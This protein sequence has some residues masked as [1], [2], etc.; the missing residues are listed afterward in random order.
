MVGAG[1]FMP[2]RT[3][4]EADNWMESYLRD[5]LPAGV[6]AAYAD[7]VLGCLLGGA[8]G[9]AF[10][11]EVEF[12]S[13]AVVRARYGDQ[14]IQ[15]PV[16]H[17]GRLVVSDDT[18]MTLFTL[19]GLLRADDEYGRINPVKAVE[20][21]R[22]AYLDWL[23]T[24]DR[25]MTNWQ[26]VG[27]LHAE[28]VMQ[29]RRAPGNTCLSALHAGAWGRVDNR[30]N[31]SKGCGGVMRVVPLGLVQAWAP[32]TAFVVA[33]QTAAIT[34]GHPSGY[35]SAAAMAAIVRMLIDGMDLL[36][37]ADE[38]VALL[39]NDPEADETISALRAATGMWRERPTDHA[40]A[41]ERLGEGWVGEEALAVG[42]YAALAGQSFR[43][44][45]AIA[46]NHDGDSDSTASIAGQL[47]GAWK[48]MADLPQSWVERLDVFDPAMRLV[49]EL[50][51]RGS[52]RLN[53]NA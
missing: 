24:Q 49:T 2:N 5:C 42:V 35:L 21:I 15:E 47:Y 22:R 51:K 36:A 1:E 38:A 17:D 34:H 46:A 33:A 10:G 40:S 18:Q 27:W 3:T 14:G 16:L 12:D 48:G 26:P 50:P 52:D 45:L 7:R 30:I 13:L 41:V 44:V 53:P 37:A 23:V 6:D 31:A 19:E 28:P 39:S 29:R 11:Y 43:E 9:D 32:A 20:E 4:D 8:V 25:F